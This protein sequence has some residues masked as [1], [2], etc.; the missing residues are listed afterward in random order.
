MR[1]I[2][3]ICVLFSASSGFS[4]K[5]ETIKLGQL[6][7]IISAKSGKIQII[8]FWATWCG[9]CVKEL[10]LFEKLTA[11][12]PNDVKVTLVSLDLDLDPDPQNVYR[13]VERKKLRSEVLLLDEADPNSWISQIDRA[14]TGA[15]PATIIINQKTG[16]RKFIGKELS[17]G[18]LEKHIEDIR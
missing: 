12:G 7:E 14:W 1:Q 4:Q 9:P 17:E 10:P 5:P 6:K 16:E 18:E 8:N 15:L 2:F 11:T 3:L 13:F